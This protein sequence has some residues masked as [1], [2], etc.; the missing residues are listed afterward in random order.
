MLAAFCWL[1]RQQGEDGAWREAGAPKSDVLLTGVALYAF[2]LAGYSPVSLSRVPDEGDVLLI[3][4]V[5]QRGV[6]WL[7][8]Q[9]NA[10]GSIGEAG[11]RSV[12][13]H[14]VATLALC[15]AY[16][17]SW[18]F[19]LKEPAK[20]AFEWLMAVQTPKRG[21]RESPDDR[22]DDTPTTAWCALALRSGSLAGFLV[23]KRCRDG[24]MAWLAEVTEPAEPWHVGRHRRPARGERSDALATGAGILT[25]VITNMSKQD[26]ALGAITFLAKELPAD[27]GG[28][29]FGTAAITS[30]DGPNGALFKRWIA[31][32]DA[33]LLAHQAAAGPERG[34]W[35]A[36]APVGR[37]SVTALNVMS[38]LAPRQFISVF[39]TRN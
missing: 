6:V 7:M 20:R 11:P 19:L 24:I 38:L 26:P 14:A 5:V 27:A 15:E 12:L 4:R 28:R 35:P 39:G 30:Y 1:A 37:A 13:A 25:R 18:H 32:L 10:D 29:F 34:S 2:L 17:L 21:W 16:G 22:D 9:Q 36:E 8:A 3:G 23:P 33:A 31:A